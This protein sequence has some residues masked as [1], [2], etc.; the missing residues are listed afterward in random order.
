[1]QSGR[2]R[3]IWRELTGVYLVVRRHGKRYLVQR[4]HLRSAVS[5][6]VVRE[7]YGGIRLLSEVWIG[8]G[9]PLGRQRKGGAGTLRRNPSPVR[10]V[11]RKWC[12]ARPSAAR[13]R[14]SGF[15]D[16]HDFPHAA[17]FARREAK[18]WRWA[19]LRPMS[20]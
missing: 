11:D 5:V 12:S 6:K 8:N 18:E 9:A 17:V 14:G 1:M 2:I 4:K 15:G 19:L 10:G 16:A 3:P 7:L 13:A 20:S